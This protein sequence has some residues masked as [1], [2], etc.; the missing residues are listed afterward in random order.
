MSEKLSLQLGEQLHRRDT[1]TVGSS[2]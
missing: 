1:G 2:G